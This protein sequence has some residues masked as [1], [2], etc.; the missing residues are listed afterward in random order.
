MDTFGAIGLSMGG[1]GCIEATG[2]PGLGID[3]AVGLAPAAMPSV[4]SAARKITVPVQLQ[5]GTND[6]FV[7]PGSVLQL[8]TDFLSNDTVKEYLV[9][10]GGNHIGFIDEFYARF[11]QRFGI[12]NPPGITYEEQRTISS[13]YFTAWFQFHLKHLSEYYTYIFGDEAQHDLDEGL[14]SDLRYNIP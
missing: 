10:T 4:L 11:G 9:I 13:R 8:Y 7:P 6:G 2:T 5:V 14:L 3:A 1:G 12:D